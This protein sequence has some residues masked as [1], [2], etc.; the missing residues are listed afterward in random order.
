MIS[1]FAT[2]DFIRVRVTEEWYGVGRECLLVGFLLIPSQTESG[3][4]TLYGLINGQ[5]G[6]FVLVAASDFISDFV[7]DVDKDRFVDAHALDVP[8][9]EVPMA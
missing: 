8:G 7:Y 9:D 4:H 2:G 3:T 6:N 1:L 5:D